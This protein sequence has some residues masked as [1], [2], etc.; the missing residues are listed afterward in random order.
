MKELKKKEC[1]TKRQKKMNP[2]TGRPTF[3]SFYLLAKSESN[4]E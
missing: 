2:F 1:D 3:L 4:G